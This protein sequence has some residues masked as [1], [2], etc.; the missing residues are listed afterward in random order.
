MGLL[1]ASEGEM[2]VDGVNISRKN[3]RSWKMHISHVPQN[4]FLTDNTIEE[5][6]A[7]G[8]HKEKI[9]HERICSA[10]NQAQLYDLIDGLEDKYQ[11]VIGENGARLSGGQRQRIGIARALYNKSDVIVFDEATSSLDGD[12]E[13]SV[14]E[15]IDRLSDD[16]TVLIIAHRI[17]TLKSCDKIFK[18]EKGRIVSVGDY[19]NVAGA[20]A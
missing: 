5:N 4:I 16:L 18:I 8:Q 13:K 15:A 1:S 11:T 6:I 12:T 10:A 20:Q 3:S 7:F 9:T 19:S 14:M 17:E 2:K